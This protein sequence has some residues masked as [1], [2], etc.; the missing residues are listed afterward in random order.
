MER[1]SL[2]VSDGAT[3]SYMEGGS[4]Q[5]L[6][7]IPGWSQSA[8]EFERQFEDLTAI[9]RVIALD[10]RGHGESPVPGGGYRIQRL[11][12]DL[13]D[14]VR[15]LDLS[16]PDFLGH[17]MGSSVMWSYMSMFGA[18]APP[19]RLV[20]VDQAPAAIARAFWSEEE[21]VDYG[22]LFPSFDVHGEFLGTVLAAD[23]PDTCK[24]VLRGM[25]TPGMDEGEL[26]WIAEQNLKLPRA[27]AVHLLHDHCIQDWRSEIQALRVPTLVVGGDISIFSAAS[28]RW[29]ANQVPG[30]KAD[31]FEADQGGSHFMFFE[32]APR[33]N[34]AVSGF[35][36]GA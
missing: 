35:L 1:K 23:T 16:A 17:S 10:M 20:V 5:P 27:H 11:A 22:C 33:F 25:F 12:K 36:G 13:F 9:A 26:T 14:V 3:L 34:A 30:G 21:K 19:R 18:D 29:I 6:V 8:A 32:N 31:I 4:G 24:E 7:M 15:A 2:T 28:Q